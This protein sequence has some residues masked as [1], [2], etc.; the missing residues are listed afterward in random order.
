MHRGL[1]PGEWDEQLMVLPRHPL[2]CLFLTAHQMWRA[3]AGE[4]YMEGT[5]FAAAAVITSVALLRRLSPY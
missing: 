4:G 1:I 2:A 3:A 5:I